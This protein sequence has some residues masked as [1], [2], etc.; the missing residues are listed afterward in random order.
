MEMNVTCI[1]KKVQT[2]VNFLEL[3]DEYD[4]AKRDWRGC[5]DFFLPKLSSKSKV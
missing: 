1:I 5:N 3:M 4:E 2:S